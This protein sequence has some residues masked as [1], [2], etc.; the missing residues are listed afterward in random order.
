M[1]DPRITYVITD[2]H[3][4]GVPLHLLRL[5]TGVRERGFNPSVVS[6][7]PGGAVADQLRI[8][9]IPTCSCNAAAARDLPAIWRLARHLRSLQPDIVHSLLFHANVASRLAIRLA[10]I[11]PDRLICEIQTV[12]VERRWHLLVGGLTHSLGRCVVGNSPS[13]VEHLQRRAHMSPDRLRCIPGGVDVDRIADAPPANREELG[14]PQS[15]RVVLWIGRLDP[16]KGLDGL[17][18]AFTTVV[19]ACDA[20]L[21]L[22]GEGAYEAAVRR[23]IEHNKLKEHVHLLGRRSDV[24]SLLKLADVFVLPSRTEGMPNA[25]LEAMAARCPVVTTDVPGCHDLV[26][27]E[28]TGLLVEYGN[29][30]DLSAGIL[31]LLGDHPLV[32]RLTNDADRHVRDHFTLDRCVDRYVAMYRES[33]A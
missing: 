12:E 29:T 11:A 5:A 1:F 14:I 32:A 13:V 28:R 27:H 15:K 23:R 18:D 6:L 10:G 33:L 2:L 31:R 7:A 4:G 20:T 3:T 8:Q 16:V 17:V 26:T 25:I 24:A 30:H 21:L 22:A 9:G 19:E